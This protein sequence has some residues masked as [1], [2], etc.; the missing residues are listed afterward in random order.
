MDI[1]IKE[2]TFV[3]NRKLPSLHVSAYYLAGCIAILSALNPTDSEVLLNLFNMLVLT[4]PP[5]VE[6]VMFGKNVVKNGRIHQEIKWNTS[7]LRCNAKPQYIIRYANDSS[8]V[9]IDSKVNY[10]SDPNTTL[11]LTFGTSNITYYVAVAVRHTGEQGRGDY[12]D[13]ISITYTSEFSTKAVKTKACTVIEYA[14]IG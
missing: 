12:S 2:E 1:T 13:L 10:N 4:G 9:L 8:G 11:Q 7:V 5:K 14:C 6:G 3:V